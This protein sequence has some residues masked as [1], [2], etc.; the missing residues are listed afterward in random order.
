M[1]H[2][3][4][5]FTLTNG[6]AVFIS[7]MAMLFIF[8]Q[9]LP[10]LN[11]HVHTDTCYAADGTQVCGKENGELYLTKSKIPSLKNIL[12]ALDESEEERITKREQ[13]TAEEKRKEAAPYLVAMGVLMITLI[14]MNRHD[15]RKQK[16]EGSA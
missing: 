5:I 3:S 14:L 9:I 4:L 11:A 2:D 10:S 15:K 16:T 8:L 12:S 7:S 13:M 6:F 1:D